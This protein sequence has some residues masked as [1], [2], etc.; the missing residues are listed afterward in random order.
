MLYSMTGYGRANGHFG[1][2]TIVVEVRALNSKSTDLKIRLPAEYKDRELELRKVI[3][4]H[5]DRGKIDLNI[6]VQNAD[7]SATVGLNEALFK[8]Y[9]HALTRLS[10]QLGAEVDKGSLIPAI[11]RIQNV[12]SGAAGDVDEEEW[13]TVTNAVSRA[14]D[15]LKEFR[16]E[17]GKVLEAD[18][19]LRVTNIRKLLQETEPF[20]KERFVRMRERIRTNAEEVFGKDN[21]DTN[22]FEQELLYYLEKMDISEEKVRLEQHC[23]YFLEQVKNDRQSAGRTLNFISQ[24]MGREINTLGAKAYD[25]DL[26]RLVIQMKDE[27]EKIKEQI[28]NIL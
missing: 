28:A 26:Q 17:E 25:A 19:C 8:G 27:L 22:R 11:L 23:N 5:A 3:L 10:A 13:N 9:F 16:T 24:E 6:D 12:V 15:A 2:K 20:D 14:L 1:E 18:M 7:G 4:D 21:F